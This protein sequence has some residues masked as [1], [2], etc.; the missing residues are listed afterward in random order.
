[1]QVCL[2]VCVCVLPH[3]LVGLVSWACQLDK[4]ASRHLNTHTHVLLGLGGN[5]VSIF[6]Q[7]V[8]ESRAPSL[9]WCG[10]QGCV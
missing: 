1:M 6:G 4:L 7:A 2:C 5:D 8:L 3:S 9:H 10:K